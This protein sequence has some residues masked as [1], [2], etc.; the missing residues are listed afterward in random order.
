MFSF[1]CKP[2]DVAQRSGLIINQIP[3]RA[4][5]WDFIGDGNKEGG[6]YGESIAE[7][8]GGEKESSQRRVSTK[9][10]ETEL[11]RRRVMVA[12]RSI[13]VVGGS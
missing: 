5:G 10:G 9:R 12:Q 1:R 11:A 3:P 4:N 8:S 6:K 13:L 2:H 7:M